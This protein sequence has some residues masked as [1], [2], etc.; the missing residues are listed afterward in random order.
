MD[1]ANFY[2]RSSAAQVESV[3]DVMFVLP[4]VG[5]LG[6]FYG[7]VFLFIKQKT[8]YEIRPRDWSSDVCSSDRH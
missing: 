7:S 6:F 5:M 1:V 3:D 4:D 8:A 2:V